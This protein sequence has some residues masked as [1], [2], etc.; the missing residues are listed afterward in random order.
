MI[1]EIGATKPAMA[2]VTRAVL[3]LLMQYAVRP[4]CGLI[5]R[6]PDS[7]PIEP[8]R[9]IRG[10]MMSCHSSSDDGRLE[11]ANG[12]HLRCCSTPVNAEAMSSKCVDRTSIME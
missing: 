5:T 12:S 6:L 11:R 3:R 9:V 8:R 10:R 1:E 4:N 2:N 7:K